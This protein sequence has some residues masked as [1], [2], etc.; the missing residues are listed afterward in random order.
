MFMSFCAFRIVNVFLI[1]SQFDP[2]EYWQQLE[3]AYCQ[4]FVGA[5]KPC[6]GLTWEWKLRPPSTEFSAL[7]DLVQ[8]GIR[9]PIRSYASILPTLGFYYAVKFFGL[10]TPWMIARGPMVVNA[11]VV[12]T[13]TD[14][15]VWYLSRWIWPSTKENGG[16]STRRWCVYCML[17][18]W[19]CAYALIRTY[20]NSLETLLLTISLCLVAPVRFHRRLVA[21]WKGFGLISS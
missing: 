3:P 11:V 14:W 13:P 18:S 15:S 5:G 2:D 7:A 9:G 21:C 10:D 12:A 19:F 8:M 6:P 20:S 1:Q 17:T 16:A 4:V